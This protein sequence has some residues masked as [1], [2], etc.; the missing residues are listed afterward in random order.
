MLGN[1]HGDLLYISVDNSI[2][3]NTIPR[4]VRMAQPQQHVSDI[5]II[6]F[7][8]QSVFISVVETSAKGP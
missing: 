7:H 6:I 2:A 5:A 8:H 4:N 1:V 3:L